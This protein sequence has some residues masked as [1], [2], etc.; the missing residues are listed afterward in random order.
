MVQNTLSAGFKTLIRKFL[1][2]PLLRLFIV[3]LLC[4]WARRHSPLVQKTSIKG[5]QSQRWTSLD[6][7]GDFGA[8]SSAKAFRSTAG[9]GYLISI[10]GSLAWNTQVPARTRSNRPKFD[11]T[12]LPAL[13]SCLIPRAFSKG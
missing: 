10:I 3:Q 8:A 9:W 13:L 12:Q 2:S 7:P 5:Y 11:A 6:I 1:S 4:K